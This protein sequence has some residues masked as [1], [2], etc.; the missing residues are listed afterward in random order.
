MSLKEVNEFCYLSCWFKHNEGQEPNIVRRVG[1]VGGDNPLTALS[2][3]LSRVIS[4]RLFHSPLLSYL[5]LTSL[6]NFLSRTVLSRFFYCPIKGYPF[7]FPLKGYPFPLFSLSYQSL[8]F[9]LSFQGLSFPV[10]SILCFSSMGSRK[11]ICR[12][13]EEKSMVD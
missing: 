6:F 1:I 4:S 13:L 7:H 11:K 5:T 10:L 3:L 8:S 12:G 2:T 9:P